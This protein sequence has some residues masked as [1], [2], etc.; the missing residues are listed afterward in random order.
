MNYFRTLFLLTGSLCLAATAWS[1]PVSPFDSK[2]LTLR[3]EAMLN[4][5]QENRQSS[6]IVFHVK[7]L[8]PPEQLSRLCVKPEITLPATT[9]LVG[10]R[11]LS[12]QCGTKKQFIQIKVGAEGTYWVSR[13]A[14]KKGHVLTS[15]DIR[16]RRGSLENLPGALLFVGTSVAGT[17]TTRAIPAGQP[18]LTNLIRQRWK[19]TQG[20]KVTVVSSGEGFNIRTSGKALDNAAVNQPLR[21]RLIGGSLA[22]GTVNSAGEVVIKPEN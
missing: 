19:V 1:S 5:P 20:A 8:T 11:T 22:T 15:N 10:N 21:V 9:R 7:V 6:S 4:T 16:P 18:I 17:V 14:L 13:V 12:L 3:I 2:D